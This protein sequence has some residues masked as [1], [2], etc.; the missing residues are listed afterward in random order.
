MAQPLVV[1]ELAAH[2]G[3]TLRPWLLSDLDLVREA[4]KDDYIP[5]I[6]TV[7]SPFSEAEGVAFIERQRRAALL[8]AGY[9]FVIVQPGV[10]PV[11]TAGLWVKN[12]EQG[13]ASV[14]YWV[15]QSARRQ[16]AAAA[17]L[18]AITEW[19]LLDL[20]IPRLELYVEP[21]NAASM[22]T[23]ERAGFRREGLL[24]GRQL[25]GE[26]RRDAF[27]YALLDGGT[28]RQSEGQG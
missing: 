15:V 12:L 19:A 4:S 24:R 1:P 10:R 18:R 2:G 13:R 20:R 26:E 23:A 11:G 3:V 28:E 21:W 25:V 16:G 8:G 27:R 7:P 5:L 17:A 6:T 14:G 22:R 9:P